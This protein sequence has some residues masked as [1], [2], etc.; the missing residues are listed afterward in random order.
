LKTQT[1]H[2]AL[3]GNSP[4]GSPL[5][6]RTYQAETLNGYRFG[7][8]S[9][10]KDD[11]IYGKGNTTTAEYWEFDT[12]LGR[13]WNVDPVTKPWQADYSCFANSPI[14]KIDPKGDDDFFNADGTFSHR[15]D[16][17]TKIFV[18]TADGNKELSQIDVYKA[19]NA[20]TLSKIEAYYASTIGVA[21]GTVMGVDKEKA[22]QTALAYSTV[23]KGKD[24]INLSAGF[25]FVSPYLN[26]YNNLKSTLF[27]EKRHLERK[28]PSKKDYKFSDHV[29][30]Y[31]DQMN[32]KTF[33]PTTFDF[34][35]GIV[36]SYVSYL[37]ASYNQGEIS[38]DEIE[39]KITDFNS[40]SKDI[41]IVGGDFN[42]AAGGYQ[43]KV[44]YKD[45]GKTK[46][47]DN[48]PAAADPN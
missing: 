21:T 10:E 8:N 35:V 47:T 22:I 4:F 33:E 36:T 9:Q 27:H 34:K 14:W 19:H 7:M 41:K 23:K 24:H 45:K 26:D 3:K 32:D 1:L 43:F 20:K 12:R 40:K 16:K 44:E 6:G 13:R 37:T 17:G 15:T 48:V 11:E 38:F 31:E 2:I 18:C 46:T 28:D 25:G 30:I 5:F 39:A 29:I 42:Q